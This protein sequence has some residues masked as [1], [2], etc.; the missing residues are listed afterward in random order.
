MHDGHHSLEHHLKGTLTDIR[1]LCCHFFSVRFERSDFV[2]SSENNIHV[3]LFWL[4]LH[5]LCLHSFEFVLN[6]FPLHIGQSCL[7]L[8]LYILSEDSFFGLECK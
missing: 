5:V 2:L 8:V 4:A 3:C 6:K 1:P 7:Q